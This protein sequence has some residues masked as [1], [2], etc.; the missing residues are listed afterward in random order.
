MDLSPVQPEW[1]PDNCDFIVGDLGSDL[2]HFD[3]GS[4]DLI[5]SRYTHIEVCDDRF[6]AAGVTSDQWPT[7]LREVFSL[8]KPGIGWAQFCELNL[9]S[10]EGNIPAG[11]LYAQ[12]QVPENF[13]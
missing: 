8:L 9:P 10:W 7:Y 4:I 2:D 6:V 3:T 1:V 13:G 11:S 5:H 12:V